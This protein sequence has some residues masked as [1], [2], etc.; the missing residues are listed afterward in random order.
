MNGPLQLR[1]PESGQRESDGILRTDFPLRRIRSLP[2][3]SSRTK[4]RKARLFW[5]QFHQHFMSSFS[6]LTVCV[7]NFLANG[8][9]QKIAHEMLA[10]LTIADE[11]ISKSKKNTFTQ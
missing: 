1:I 11:N 5:G 7:C 2:T 8:I 4:E 9:W 10:K 6:V 3:S